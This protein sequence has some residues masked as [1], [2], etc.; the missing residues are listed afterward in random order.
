VSARV[1]FDRAYY[2]PGSF[3]ERASALRDGF[4]PVPVAVS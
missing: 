1:T 4:E 3:D 2:G